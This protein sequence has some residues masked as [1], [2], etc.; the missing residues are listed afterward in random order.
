MD[1]SQIEEFR[2]SSKKSF[3]YWEPKRSVS[4]LVMFAHDTVYDEK[5]ATVAAVATSPDPYYCTVCVAV[6]LVSPHGILFD[7]FQTP[8]EV[9]MTCSAP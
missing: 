2:L 1:C 4:S 8:A 9:T 7:D 3:V 5:L 6:N